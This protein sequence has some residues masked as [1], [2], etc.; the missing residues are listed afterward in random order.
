MSRETVI[1]RPL[2]CVF[3]DAG[4]TLLAPWPT[5]EGRLVAVAREHGASFEEAAAQAAIAAVARR[6]AWPANWTDP[7]LQRDFWCG[8][9]LEVLRRLGYRGDMAALARALYGSFSDP[10]SYRLF[11]DVAPAL[12]S[13]AARGLKL[14]VISNFEPW[15]EEVLRREGI[16][17]L[18]SVLAISGVLGVAKPEP[19]IFRAALD[20]VG[21]A[22]STA[23]HVG[24]HPEMDGTA[25]RAVGITPVLI[26][27]Y[28]RLPPE[29][30]PRIGSLT[31][32]VDLVDAE[33]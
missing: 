29:A 22:A 15:L 7:A 27:R 30:G 21:V 5:F 6:T 23:I 9:Y 32:L 3:L 11:G 1:P 28:G 8:F 12:G 2:K 4:D 31:E 19:A 24:D 20:Q 26:D 17:E 14:G 33:A 10:A 25:A 18:F 13:L 16:L